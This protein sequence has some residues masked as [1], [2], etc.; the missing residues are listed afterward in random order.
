M[1]GC[2]NAGAGHLNFHIPLTDMLKSTFQQYAHLSAPE[3][4]AAFSANDPI[5]D[6]S[7]AD[8][9]ALGL[10]CYD[11]INWPSPCPFRDQDAQ[12]THDPRLYH[13]DRYI[14]PP[15]FW[16]SEHRSIPSNFRTPFASMNEYNPAYPYLE[17]LL[18]VY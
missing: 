14:E 18:L 5:L 10:V 11:I 17:Q 13:D 15:T 12:L 7:K 9:F 16:I 6:F 2:L 1:T 8:V 4:A 3:L